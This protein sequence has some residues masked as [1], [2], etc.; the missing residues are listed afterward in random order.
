MGNPSAAHEPSMEEILA[1]IRQII[2]EDSD[3]SPGTNAGGGVESGNGMAH[4]AKAVSSSSVN[5]PA[6]QSPEHRPSIAA[7]NG[8]PMKS[9]PASAPNGA[10]TS[11]P[12][13]AEP[14]RKEAAAPSKSRSVAIPPQAAS[15]EG[16][17]L[18]EGADSAVSGAFSALAHTILA[19]NARTLEDLVSEMLR[20]MLREWLDDNLPTLVERIVQDEIQ[21]VSRGRR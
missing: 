3:A 12:P 9:T 18:S 13:V 2:S 10:A 15:G 4:A 8:A 20:P 11:F 6:A 19:Q 7:F 17:L 21:R 14:H 1:S 16:R 5:T